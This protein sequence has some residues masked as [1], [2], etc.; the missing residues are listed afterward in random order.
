MTLVNRDGF[1]NI[2]VRNYES[3]LTPVRVSLD[4]VLVSVGVQRVEGEVTGIDAAGT[5]RRSENRKRATNFPYDRLVFALGSQL[6]RLNVAG[7]AEYAFDVDTYNGGS[8]LNTH[9]QSLP[10]DPN[11]Q[12]CLRSSSWA[13]A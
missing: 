11:L 12:G 9:L 2:R 7:L 1:H 3:D 13:P 4:D 6:L 5:D 8:R 10:A